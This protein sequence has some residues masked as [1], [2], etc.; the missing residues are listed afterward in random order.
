MIWDVIINDRQTTLE[1][2]NGRFI[3]DNYCEDILTCH[4]IPLCRQGRA[5]FKHDN[6]PHH[7]AYVTNKFLGQPRW[8]RYAIVCCFPRYQRKW[9]CLVMLEDETSTMN[10][11]RKLW[12]PFWKT[13]WTLEWAHSCLYQV[14]NPLNASQ[15]KYG[16]WS[17]WW[18]HQI[19]IFIF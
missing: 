19:L 12:P 10:N 11:V 17:Q 8:Q 18:P 5:V 15:A 2:I 7:K 6:A 1:K 4:V 9:A 13:V 3:K 16:Y 14:I